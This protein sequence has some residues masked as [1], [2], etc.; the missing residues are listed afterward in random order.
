MVKFFLKTGDPQVDEEFTPY[1]WGE[2]GLGAFIETYSNTEDYGQ[3]LKL[4]LIQVYVEGR[5]AVN[6]PNEVSVGNYSRV[7]QETSAAFTVRREDFQDRDDDKR[8]AF[9]SAMVLRAVTEVERKHG[10]KAQQYD[11]QALIESVVIAIEKYQGR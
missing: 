5:F 7:R 10:K 2:Q 4:L 3:G 9:L 8:K 11:F 1:L 6:G